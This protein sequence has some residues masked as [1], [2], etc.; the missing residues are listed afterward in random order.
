MPDSDGQVH[1]PPRIPRRTVL[2]AMGAGAFAACGLPFVPGTGAGAQPVREPRLKTATASTATPVTSVLFVMLENH[3]FDNFFGSFPGVNGVASAPAPNPMGCDINHTRAHYVA[4]FNAG[5]DGFDVRGVVSYSEQDVPILW[6]YARHF[7]L[8]DNFYTSAAASSSPNHIY[9]LAAQSAGLDETNAIPGPAG[10]AV[11]GCLSRPNN[12]NGS[13]SPTGSAYMQYP[14]LDIA[15]VPA[16][17]EGAGVSWRYYCDTAIWLAPWYIS[18]LAQSPNVVT[19]VDQVLTDIQD[20]QLASVSWVCPDWPYS[21]HPPRLLEAAQ[22]FVANLTNAV[23]NSEYWGT[24]AIFVTWDDWGGFYDHVVPPVIDSM[25]L[26]PRVPLLVISPYAIPGYISHAQAEFSSLVK[27]VEFNWG[28]PSLDQRDANPDISDL[29]DFF[30]FGQSPQ[31]PLLQTLLPVNEALQVY[32][33]PLV[34]NPPTGG[35]STVFDFVIGCIN[36]TL[37]TVSNVIIDGAA[38]EMVLSTKSPATG[39]LE[40]T[41]DEAQ[42]DATGPQADVYLYSTSLA[43]G[44]HTFSF[45]FV[46]DGEPVIVPNNGQSYSVDV[47]PFDLVNRTSFDDYLAGSSVVFEVVY[48]SPEGRPP[49]LSQ[50]QLAGVSYD[51][52]LV[53]GTPSTGM[54]YRFEAALPAG[55]YYYR[56]QF[57]DGVATGTYEQRQTG[58]F[59]NLMVAGGTVSPAQGTTATVF[60]FGTTYTN[61]TGAPPVSALVYVDSEG[62][63]MG[64]VSG[65]AATGALY[66]AKVHLGTG[67]HSYA[68]VFSDGTTSYADPLISPPYVGPDVS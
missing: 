23:M 35:P 3:T 26:G 14:C 60:T 56:F 18:S 64:Y 12:L 27:F 39:M 45:S 13:I 41:G 19:N 61:T 55:Y 36:A 57:S 32:P 50:L 37:P 67:E 17:L 24:A 4:S 48:T 20:G 58:F 28:L 7:G 8:S 22:N 34:V 53:S 25:G 66:E 49:T 11:S 30:D 46:V 6:Q 63:E 31:P 33:Y 38:Y 68:F 43:P 9:M 59:T 65:S 21:D 10:K 62:Y 5:M 16:L 42:V 15:S 29:T 1:R 54:T 40:T 2:K 52:H 47:M 51:M 44:G